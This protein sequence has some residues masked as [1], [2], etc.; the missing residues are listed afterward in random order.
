MPLRCTIAA[1]L[2]PLLALAFA[3]QTPVSDTMSGTS[4]FSDCQA[5]VR[6]NDKDSKDNL[7]FGKSQ[8]C[9]GYIEGFTTGVI[10]GGSTGPCFESA[11][12]GTLIRVYI[13]YMERHPALLDKPKYD[14]LSD[15]LTEAYPCKAKK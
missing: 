2:A 5:W 6:F 15:A 3:V 8:Y 4:L 14:G 1:M 13:A 11:T 10:F 7:D 9:N 12:V